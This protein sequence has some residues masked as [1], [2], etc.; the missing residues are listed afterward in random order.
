MRS[1]LY[2]LI[3]HAQAVVTGLAAIA[4]AFSALSSLL[5]WR[6]QRSNLLESVRPELVLL[7]WHRV[8][9]RDA[10]QPEIIAFRRVRN[11]GR[12]VALFVRLHLSDQSDPPLANMGTIL[13]SLIEAGGDVPADGTIFAW[14]KNAPTFGQEQHRI[15][16]VIVRV[17]CQDTRGNFYETSNTVRVVQNG[18]FPNEIARGVEV[19]RAPA[20]MTT[21]RR[22]RLRAR[23]NRLLIKLGRLP[24]VIGKLFVRNP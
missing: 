7:D 19:H 20:T 22:M 5:I 4:A 21:A 6:V 9:A 13:L 17:T 23:R 16:S 12:G 14:F 15:I 11:A 1:A 2:W 18:A 24:A 8:P 10:S 3:A